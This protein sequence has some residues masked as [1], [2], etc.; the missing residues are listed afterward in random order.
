MVT[1]HK[2]EEEEELTE[3]CPLALDLLREFIQCLLKGFNNSDDSFFELFHFSLSFLHPLSLGLFCYVYSPPFPLSPS[4]FSLHFSLSRCRS[5]SSSLFSFSLLLNHKLSLS[6]STYTASLRA[7]RMS[8][9]L[10]RH[11]RDDSCTSAPRLP[12]KLAQYP[13]AVKE[14]E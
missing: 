13:K 2:E 9:L 14:L 8:E 7:L 10:S 12:N 3:C 4:L 1:V 6:L 11:V 5:L